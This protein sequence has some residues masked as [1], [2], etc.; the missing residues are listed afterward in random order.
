MYQSNIIVG[1]FNTLLSKL[2]KASRQ[3]INKDIVELDSTINQMDIILIYW[4]FHPKT[5]EYTFF[6]SSLLTFTKIDYIL[7]HKIHLNLF[8]FKRIEIIWCAPSD[9]KG[10]KLEIKNRKITGKSFNTWRLNKKLLN[11]TGV[12]GEVSRE[13]KKYFDLNEN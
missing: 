6:S 4:P 3:K 9:H 13:I 5:E 11:N 8:K 1:D 10:I 12:K 2:D 7:H